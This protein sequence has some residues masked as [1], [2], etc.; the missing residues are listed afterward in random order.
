M[1][2]GGDVCW[3]IWEQVYR[4]GHF[5]FPL[6]AQVLEIG[7]AELDWQ[8]LMLAKRPDLSITGIDW[9]A[10]DR[11]GRTIQGDVLT[12]DF[13]AASFDAIVGIS[14]IEHIGLGHYNQDPT[15]S[16]GDSRAVAAAARW[17]RPGG[18][19]YADVP[20]DPT[21]YRLNGTKC[22][23]YDE[24]ALKERLVNPFCPKQRRR[25]YADYFGV[26]V[27]PP[28][29]APAKDQRWYYVALWMQKAV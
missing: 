24:A 2:Q 28:T 22:R 3:N 12:Y 10:C 25:Y 17:L 19:F 21:G 1:S 26:P 16:D 9:R 4:H 6:Y 27:Q 11:P 18:W 5:D 13:P 8:T 15:N 14:S 20:F 23:V 7:C 29:G